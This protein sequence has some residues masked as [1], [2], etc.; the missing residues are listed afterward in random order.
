M[1]LY[2][3]YF[4]F[5]SF[6]GWIIEVVYSTVETGRFVNRGFLNG[7]VCPVYGFGVIAVMKVLFQIQENILLLFVGA[8]VLTSLI[9]LVAGW[10]LMKIFN[11]RWWD[12]SDEHFNFKGYVCLKFSLFWGLGCM[13]II[14]II[15]PVLQR[16]I[17]YLPYNYAIVILVFLIVVLF[18]D[19]I[20]TIQTI[21]KLNRQLHE[22]NHIGRIIHELSDDL[23]GVIFHESIKAMERAEELKRQKEKIINRN[24]FGKKRI[25]KAFPKMSSARYADE[26]IQLK[27]NI[28][29]FF[30]KEKKSEIKK[31]SKGIK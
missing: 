30:D 11:E 28:E 2:I 26:L 20:A 21:L 6:A 29:N 23:G 3:Y 22:I 13:F 25:I 17:A 7:P 27:N 14:E 4:L 12:Y 1:Y 15:H 5:Y 10:V 16:V 19:V 8:V 9:E 31:N 18:I 24:F